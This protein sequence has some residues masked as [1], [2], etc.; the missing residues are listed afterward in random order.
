MA[1]NC[2]SEQRSVL[3]ARSG[4]RGG[5]LSG[6]LLHVCSC[7]A[8]TSDRDPAHEHTLVSQEGWVQHPFGDVTHTLHQF[9]LVPP[10]PALFAQLDDAKF[11]QHSVSLTTPSTSLVSYVPSQ[12]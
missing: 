8:S 7:I 3:L 5:S 11:A 10:F 1:T 2:S 12:F 4:V 6:D 9:A